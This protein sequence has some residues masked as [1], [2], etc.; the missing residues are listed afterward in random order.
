MSHSKL[1]EE[2][3]KQ[4]IPVL[5][6]GGT[7]RR[8]WPLSRPSNPKPFLQIFGKPSLYQNTWQRVDGFSYYYVCAN[9][10][11]YETLKQQ[12][13]QKHRSRCQFFMEPS[14]RGTAPAIAVAAHYLKRIKPDSYMW[15]LPTDHSI[16]D[17]AQ[18]HAALAHAMVWAEQGKIVSFVVEAEKISNRFGYFSAGQKLSG[19]AYEAS[20]FVE[21]PQGEAMEK[22]AGTSDVFCNTGMFLCKPDVFLQ[23]LRVHGS[24]LYAQTEDAVKYAGRAQDAILLNAERFEKIEDVSVDKAVFEKLDGHILQPV[25]TQWSDNGS[26]GAFL[27]YQISG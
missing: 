18:L 14:G 10:A 15:V 5:L 26:W 8:L 2:I 7:G 21:K 11:L 27:R 6:A 23:A 20:A 1:P 4:I 22:L 19:T 24:A 17:I 12:T 3:Q 16:K 25:D 9:I 13:P